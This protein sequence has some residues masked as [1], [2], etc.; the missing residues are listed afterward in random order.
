[1]APQRFK[2]GSGISRK[3]KLHLKAVSSEDK[4]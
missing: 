1:M 4:P 3:Q 2:A